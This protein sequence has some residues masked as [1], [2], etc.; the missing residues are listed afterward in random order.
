MNINDLVKLMLD[1]LDDLK[2]EYSIINGKESL[3]INDEEICNYDDSKLIKKIES[4]KE[5]LNQLDD[6]TFMDV[7]DLLKKENVNLKALNEFMDQ[8][9]YTK[10]DEV[11]ADNYISIVSNAI[12]SVIIKKCEMFNNILNQ[13]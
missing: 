1:N 7:V 8:E 6:C 2:I 4:H 11:V 9:H 13:L 12:E 5:L 10:L 3:K